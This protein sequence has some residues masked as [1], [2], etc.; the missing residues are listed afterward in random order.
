MEPEATEA[1]AGAAAS[2]E[3]FLAWTRP[4]TFVAA[5]ILAAQAGKNI[6]RG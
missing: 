2:D 3:I 4:E 1:T 5:D 6:F